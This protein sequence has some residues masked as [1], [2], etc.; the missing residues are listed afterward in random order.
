MTLT[1]RLPQQLQALLSNEEK[2]SD[3]EHVIKTSV[4]VDLIRRYIDKRV[5]E[6]QR[7]ERGREALSEPNWAFNQAHINGSLYELIALQKLILTKE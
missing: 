3:I 6:L 5:S 4:G 2:K 1:Y 7:I